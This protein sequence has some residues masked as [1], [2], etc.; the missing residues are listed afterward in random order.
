[1]IENNFNITERAADKIREILSTESPG[2]FFRIQVLGGGCSGFQ[3]K[4]EPNATL[5]KDDAIFERHAVKILIDDQSMMFLANSEIDYEEDLGG[6]S[7]KIINPN[8][9]AKCGCGN[10]F[11]I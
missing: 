4:L 11:A 3:Y 1:M 8:S 6:A 5:E 10:S 7:F 9:T 2:E